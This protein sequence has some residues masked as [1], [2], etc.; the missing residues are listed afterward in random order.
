[1]FCRT[2]VAPH[3]LSCSDMDSNR[4]L[5]GAIFTWRGE[6]LRCASESL[7]CSRRRPGESAMRGTMMRRTAAETLTT[8]LRCLHHAWVIAAGFAL[9][10]SVGVAGSTKASAPKWDPSQM[11]VTRCEQELQYRVGREAGGR[12][13]QVVIDYRRAQVRPASN[14]ETRV[15]GSAR[16]SA[17][18]MIAA[19]TSPLIARSTVEPDRPADYRWAGPSWGGPVSGS[20]V[21]P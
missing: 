10:L 8:T 13:P 21:R 16:Y 17:M 5:R 19:A 18:P 20:W 12:S 7:L 6:R 3:G 14:A 4:N 1:M 11:A 9:S 2:R 15:S